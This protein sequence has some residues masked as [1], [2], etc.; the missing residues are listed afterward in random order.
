MKHTWLIKKYDETAARRLA[1][2]LNIH[3]ITAGILAARN[4]TRT[5]EAFSFLNPS[6]SQAT[7]PFLMKGM[8]QAVERIRLALESDE[9]IGIFSERNK[10]NSE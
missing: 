8:R 10:R 1:G 2:E 5:A 7:S 9:T 4:I 6:L 3:P